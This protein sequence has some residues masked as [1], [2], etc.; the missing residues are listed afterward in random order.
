M[1]T[2]GLLLVV[3]VLVLT[4]GCGSSNSGGG[5]TPRITSVT[6]SCSPMTITYGGTSQCSATVMGTGNFSTA[7]T[8]KVSTGTGTISSSG[9]YTAPS[10]GNATLMVTITATSTQDTSKSGT[11]TITVNPAGT[12]TSVTDSCSPSTIQSNQTSQCSATVTGTGNFSSDVTWT[13]SAG[14]ISSSGLFTAPV[15]SSPTQVTITATSSQDTSKSGK[16]IVTVNPGAA[17]NV[18]PIIVDSGPE[19][20]TF[21][22]ANEGFVTVTVCVPG[23]NTCQNIDHVL[24]DT[25]SFGLRLLSSASGGELTIP[26][27]QATDSTGNPLDE[28]LVFLDG[29]I[30]GPVSAADIT[31]AG[32]KASSAAVQVVIPSSTSPAPPA[33]CSNQSPPGGAGNEGNSVSGLGAN[34]ILGVGVFQQDCGPFCVS[35]SGPPYIYFSCPSSGCVPTTLPLAQQIPNPVIFFASDNNGVL[36]Q[37]PAVPNGGS[38]NVQGSL[39]FGIGTQANNALGSAQVYG[40]DSQ[41]DLTTTFNG[42]TYPQSFIDSGSNGIFFLDS[43][44]TG[45][46]MCA[47]PNDSWYCPTISPDNL[48]AG[49]QGTNMSSPV[50]FNFTIEDA[51][52]LF[53][54]NGGNNT[55]FSTLGAPNPGGFD[56]GLAFFYGRNMFT[57]IENMGAPGGTPPYV[58]Y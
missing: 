9:M 26:L 53:S 41:A 19:P 57:A 18:L 24:V 42:T 43:A 52:T 48:S 10:G 32:E 47:K 2:I 20:Q 50:M 45:I 55:A 31:M 34:G 5:T 56:W 22:A 8:W 11:T 14:S 4:A 6:D 25:G 40:V 29:Y 3:G 37:L 33:L 16:T 17:N 35:S 27:P 49:N 23:T 38:A 36:V 39:I 58:A 13:A 28:C 44:T 51:S 1:R 21:F 46:P 12:I 7:V 30:W 15:V 54:N